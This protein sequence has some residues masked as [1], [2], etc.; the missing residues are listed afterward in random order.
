MALLSGTEG[1]SYPQ[2]F[3]GLARAGAAARGLF[4]SVPPPGLILLGILSLQVG[5]GLAKNLFAV[6][7]PGAVVLLR[8]LTAAVVLLLFARPKLAGQSWRN[9]ALAGTFGVSL[10]LMNFA[11]Y[12]SFSRIP[13]GVAVTIEFLGPL[14]VAVAASRRRL[15][16][17]WALLAG[18]GVLMLAEG[19]SVEVVGVLWALLA[20]AAWAAYILFSTAVGKRFSGSS[21]LTV[22]MCVGAVAML[23]VGVWQGGSAL[24]KPE[25][26]ALAAGVGL[27][28]SAIPYALEMEALRKVPPKV[29]S[30]LMSLEPAVAALVGLVLLGEILGVKQW[31]A[32][33]CV[34]A[35]SIGSTRTSRRD[36]APPPE[37]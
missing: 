8:L 31:L 34:V 17:V 28:S 11:I 13:L 15:D 4:D 3:S 35:A 5:A 22:A 30:I 20:G 32:I 7:P 1:A 12:Q 16:L 14:A 37:A 23:P 27:L 29:F 19:G 33:G 2:R 21:G 18:G 26:L 25:Y 24:L 6:L 10:A 36:S 9:L